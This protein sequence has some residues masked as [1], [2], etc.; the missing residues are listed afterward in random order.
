MECAI[1]LTFLTLPVWGAEPASTVSISA[2]APATVCV[3]QIHHDCRCYYSDD[4]P[5]WYGDVGM[6]FCQVELRLSPPGR[7]PIVWRDIGSFRHCYVQLQMEGGSAHNCEIAWEDRVREWHAYW[8]IPTDDQP[9][10]MRGA[11]RPDSRGDWCETEAATIRAL[12]EWF[13][14]QPAG[15][16]AIQ[17]RYISGTEQKW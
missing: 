10:G 17:R 8:W 11:V 13:H 6:S 4:E 16:I 12:V 14:G 3:T 1:F 2:A 9:G 5:Y 7:F 15:G